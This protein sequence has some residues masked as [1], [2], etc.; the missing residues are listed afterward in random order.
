MTDHDDEFHP[1]PLDRRQ[2]LA[3][4]AASSAGL[5]FGCGGDSPT[6]PSSSGT[7][8]AT[9]GSTSATC[10]VAPSETVGPFP[11]LSDLV[12]SDIRE[13]KPGATLTLR[14]AVV[15]TSANCAPVAG[16]L[17]DVW[18]CDAA[19][20]YSSY[21]SQTGQTYLRGVQTTNANGEVVFTTVYPGWYQGRA[22]HIHID[23]LRGA[24][25]VKVTQIA[26][27]EAVNA[28]VYASGVYASRG[29][30]TTSN[31][32]DGVF[33]DSLNSQ[34]ATVTGD[35]ARGYTATFQIGVAL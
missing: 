19:G 29:P 16:V 22:T 23:V 15:N 35:P 11:S 32:R 3:L 33:S 21:G 5:T 30:N 9:G 25:S 7:T 34:V 1:P 31:A 17:V 4:L 8:T 10:S 12:R 20:N 13:G 6:S 24:T 28:A 18:Q 26:F 27:P 2:V 14:L